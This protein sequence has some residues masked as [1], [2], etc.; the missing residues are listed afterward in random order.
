MVVQQYRTE[1][2]LKR[3]S[4]NWCHYM[5][6]RKTKIY[7]TS[8][9]VKV[10]VIHVYDCDGVILTHTEPQRQIVDAQYFYNFLEL[11]L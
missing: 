2:Q 10:M 1:P 3:Q 11:N 8:T 5:S 9:N 4:N 7:H 6:P